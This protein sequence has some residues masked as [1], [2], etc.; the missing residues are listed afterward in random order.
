MPIQ[1]FW[2]LLNKLF[3]EFLTDF[4][5]GNA[6][7]RYISTKY[8]TIQNQPAIRRDLIKREKYLVPNSLVMS[9]GCPHH[10]N[11]C[12]KDAFFNGGK[13]FYTQRVD[14]I[15][16]E[17]SRLE[18]RHLYFLDD[19]LFGNPKLSEELFEEMKGLNRVFSGG[20]YC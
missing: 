2:V 14:E 5:N 4:R 3:P 9:R 20:C 6:K 15:L 17:I 19:H 11:F 10:C 12:Y 16:L 8:R 7:K 13:S 18:G 1:F